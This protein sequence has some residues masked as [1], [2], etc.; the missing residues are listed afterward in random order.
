MGLRRA[1]RGG[2]GRTWAR[3]LLGLYGVGLIGAGIFRADPSLGFPV[4]TPED[5]MAMSWHGY[6]HMVC[7]KVVLV[8]IVG[9][10][11]GW[12]R[13]SALSA[14]TRGIVEPGL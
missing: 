5:Y 10:V 11:V 7:L 1:L 14:S 8:G 12:A 9:V 6:T 13:V 3:R 2:R 4:G